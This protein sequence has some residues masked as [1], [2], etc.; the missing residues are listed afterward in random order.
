MYTIDMLLV[1]I[2]SRTHYCARILSHTL[3]LLSART[4]LP[5]KIT[6]LKSVIRPKECGDTIFADTHAAYEGLDDALKTEIQSLKGNYCYLKL[7][8]IGNDG[9][10]ENLDL[11]EIKTAANCAVHPL[12]TT[13]P[14][15]GRR[16]LYA[17]PSHTASVVGLDAAAS[18]S[19][20]QRLFEH[21]AKKEYALTH[22]YSDHDLIIWDNRGTIRFSL[23]VRAV[24]TARCCSDIKLTDFIDISPLHF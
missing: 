23:H 21:T 14:V 24:L 12:V 5:T 4:P 16:N 22:A 3:T 10:A 7:R 19:L 11:E 1:P 18:E 8:E 9:K 2:T 15:T 6:V 20:L 17:N 13:H